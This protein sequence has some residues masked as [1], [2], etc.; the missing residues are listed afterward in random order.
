M[1][2]KKILILLALSSSL[3]TLFVGCKNHYF[4]RGMRDTYLKFRGRP[5][6]SGYTIFHNNIVDTGTVQKWK[7]ARKRYKKMEFGGIWPY[8]SYQLSLLW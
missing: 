6:I 5:S 2:L 3:L 7:D 1:K 4:L 8:I